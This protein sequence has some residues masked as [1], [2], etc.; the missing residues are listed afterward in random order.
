MHLPVPPS[1]P[2]RREWL[3][4][5]RVLLALVAVLACVATACGSKSDSAAD[6]VAL[7]KPVSSDVAGDTTLT[8]G[9]PVTQVALE[10]AAL[11]EKI[12]FHV[13]FANLSGGPQTMEAFRA[14]APDSVLADPAKAAGIKAYVKYWALAQRWIKDHPDEW[15]KAYYE[16]DQ[17]LDAADGKWLIRNAGTPV[18]P[19]SWTKPIAEHQE[20]IDLLAQ[21]EDQP[22]TKAKNL[23]DMRFEHVAGQSFASAA[24]R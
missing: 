20:T 23:W 22:D 18:I 4:R 9:D 3:V 14:H 16:D 19:T 6:A 2:P 8:I 15:L 12:P 17:G 24:P 11:V 10:T 13:K 21:E 5:S 7:D 1:T